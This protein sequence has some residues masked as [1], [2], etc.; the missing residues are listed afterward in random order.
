LPR[1]AAH[2]VG[3]LREK[4]GDRCSPPY[5][6]PGGRQAASAVATSPGQNENLPPTGVAAEHPAGMR[7]QAPAR[8]LHHL[9]K[10][11]PDF[12]GH[13]PIRL[14]HLVD[15]DR[16]DAHHGFSTDGLSHFT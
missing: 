5:K 13:Q 8:V 3:G 14:P 16:C 12:L 9:Q 1:D 11:Y 7:C 15:R 10:G 4:H 2:V 6:T